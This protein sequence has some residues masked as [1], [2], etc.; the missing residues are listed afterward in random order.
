MQPVRSRA[1]SESAFEDG[2]GQSQN[3]RACSQPREIIESHMDTQNH[4]FRCGSVDPVLTSHTVT[5]AGNKGKGKIR[6]AHKY[7]TLMQLL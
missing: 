3:R 5:I 2:Q 4:S 7:T 6:F 1:I